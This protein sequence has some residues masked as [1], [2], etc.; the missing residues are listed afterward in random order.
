VKIRAIE[1]GIALLFIKLNQ[2]K[3]KKKPLSTSYKYIFKKHNWEGPHAGL[4]NRSQSDAFHKTLYSILIGS[5]FI[6][7]IKNREK[8]NKTPKNL[9][10]ASK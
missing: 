2:N 4:L 5:K 8:K 1:L 10:Y 7:R 6:H 9:I 3:K